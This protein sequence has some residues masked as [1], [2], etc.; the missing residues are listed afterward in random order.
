MNSDNG[1]LKDLGEFLRARR[2]E[3]SP[4]AV[5]LPAG[6]VARRVPGLRREEVARLAAISTDYYRRLEQGRMAASGAVLDELARVLRLTDDQR[7]YLF[8]LAGKPS[9]KARARSAQ[10][11]SPQL[12]RLLDQL[13]EAAALVLGS[14]MDIIA[15]N[16]L[17]AALITDFAQIPEERRNYVR[18]VFTDPAMRTLYPDWADVARK[19]VTNLHMDAALHPDDPRLA[20]LVIELSTQDADFREWWRGQHV[21]AKGQGTKRFHHPLVGE[22]TLDWDTLICDTAPDQHVIVLTAQPGTPSHDALRILASWAGEHVPA[23]GPS[24][25]GTPVA[26]RPLR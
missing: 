22:L 14:G 11:I 17:A 16:R 9:G 6:P 13:P 8:E 18:M 2:G 19:A 24:D 12:R 23:A 4:Q 20:E 15:W 3:L 10:E 21:E 1:R 7:V 25:S 5:G 26:A